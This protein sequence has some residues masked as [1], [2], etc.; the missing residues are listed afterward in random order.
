MNFRCPRSVLLSAVTI[1]SR[2]VAN[3]STIPALEGLLIET[4]PDSLTLTGYN[5][6]TGIRTHADAE[7]R[8]QGR[9]VLNAKLL[10]DILRKMPEGEVSFVSDEKL[11]VKLTCS[12]SYFEITGS[13]PEEF[14]ELPAVETQN[15]YSVAESILRDMIGQTIFCVSVNESRPIHTGSLFEISGPE[16]TIVSVDGFRL[17]LR[18]EQLLR[19]AEA[20]AS[21]VV[22]AAALLEVERI[23][24]ENEDPVTISLGARHIM[25][26]IQQTEIIS[27]RL[28][29][30]FLDYRRSVPTASDFCIGAQRRE[31]LNVFERMDLLIS[32]KFKSPVR[33]RFDE[34]LLR[35]RCATALGK[36]TDECPVDGDARGMEI[37]FNNRYLLEAL[38][39][40]PSDA[41]R[42]LLTNGV[43]PCVIVPP[44]EE[45]H[46]FLYLILP[47]RIRSEE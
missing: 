10:G 41:L 20:D 43:S 38:R 26:T 9:L 45:D 46:S 30:E 27:R 4:G 34:G 35:V 19:P 11:L 31:L 6:K 5:L 12:M 18:R 24:G 15:S 36:A 39:T 40:A 2:T 14:P 3:K 1:A 42:L 21:F 47:V 37:G 7:V 8:E 44:E 25:F 16:L 32:E 23:T 33:C 28:E 17:A 13:D 29:G 22:P